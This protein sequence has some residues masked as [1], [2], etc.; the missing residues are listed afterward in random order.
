MMSEKDILRNLYKLQRNELGNKKELSAIICES[1]FK[2]DEY[3]N[4]ESIFLYASCGS[5]VSTDIIMH[6]AFADKKRVA[7]PKC[8]DKNGN[9]R[10]YYIN[11]QNELMLGCYGIKAPPVHTEAFFGDKNTLCIV[12]GIA[13][14]LD[15]YRLGYGKGYYDRFLS[16][17][18]GISI[19]LCYDACLAENIP[20]DKYDKKVNYLITDKRIYKFT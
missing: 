14:S 12:P 16:E 10:F 11:S 1:L 9:M 15:G 7:F 17:F 18:K 19:G 8:I 3:K 2:T 20:A 5:E 13:F 6:K 4:C